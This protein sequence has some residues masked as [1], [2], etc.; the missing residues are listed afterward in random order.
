MLS[1]FPIKGNLVFSNGP[2]IL[3]EN[4]SKCPILISQ[5]LDNFIVTEELLAKALRNLETYVLANNN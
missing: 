3:R 5:G 4:P 2:K 1:I